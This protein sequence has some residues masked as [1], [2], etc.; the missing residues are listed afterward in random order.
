MGQR[1]TERDLI[2]QFGVMLTQGLMRDCPLPEADG[3]CLDEEGQQAL[4]THG[5]HRGNGFKEISILGFSW[6]RS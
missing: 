5:T 1:Y 4:T 2:I 6:K 3:L